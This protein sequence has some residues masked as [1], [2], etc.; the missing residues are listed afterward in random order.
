MA[1]AIAVA[2]TRSLCTA[3]RAINSRPL[4]AASLYHTVTLSSLHSSRPTSTAPSCTSSCRCRP[5]CLPL[6]AARRMSSAAS[7]VMLDDAKYIVGTYA[8][9]PFEF[10]SGRGSTLVDAA[11]KEYIDF[12][13]GIA[14]NALGHSHPGWVE[15]VKTQADKSQQTPQRSR[16]VGIVS[17]DTR[18]EVC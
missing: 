16:Q 5:R 7:S 13:S 4:Q 17:C 3:Y 18:V 9:Q 15:A 1:A 2:R 8:R 12:Y 10:V 11:G 6:S 14:V